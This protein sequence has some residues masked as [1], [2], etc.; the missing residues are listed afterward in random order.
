MGIAVVCHFLQPKPPWLLLAPTINASGFKSNLTIASALITSQLHPMRLVLL[1]VAFGNTTLE[2]PMEQ[3]DP[4]IAIHIHTQY[5]QVSVHLTDYAFTTELA[6]SYTPRT[7]ICYRAINISRQQIQLWTELLPPYRITCC[8]LLMLDMCAWVVLL[9]FPLSGSQLDIA[10]SWEGFVENRDV[11]SRVLDVQL[12]KKLVSRN[13]QGGTFS[14]SFHSF[15]SVVLLS[16]ELQ[17]SWDPGGQNSFGFFT[18]AKAIG[19]RNAAPPA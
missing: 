14:D 8:N 1:F 16:E 4:G 12:L 18:Q 17:F 2:G 19:G 5:C 3:W 6:H 9:P 7:M 10:S 15:A 11:L 13:H